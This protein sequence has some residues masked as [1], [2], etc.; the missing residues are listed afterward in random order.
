M[1]KDASEQ[2]LSEA[3]FFYGLMFYEYKHN[4]KEAVYWFGKAAEQEDSDAQYYLGLCYYEGHG[5]SVN[6]AR[7]KYWW[8]KSAAQLN[9]SARQKLK[10]LEILQLLDE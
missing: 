9:S 10:M 8:E 6:M 3:Q 1:L 2:G 4:Y 7:A 5:V